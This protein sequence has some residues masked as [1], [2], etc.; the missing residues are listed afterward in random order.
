MSTQN[1]GEIIDLWVALDYAIRDYEFKQNKPGCI[2]CGYN[3]ENRYGAETTYWNYLSNAA[4]DKFKSSMSYE[5]RDQYKKAQGGELEEKK[6]KYGDTCPP[7][8]ASF[9]SSSRFVYNISREIDGFNF[10][11]KLPTKVGSSQANI[12]GY[13][14]H[15]GTD[16]FVEAKCREIYYDSY[17]KQEVSKSYMEIYTELKKLYPG[18]SFKDCGQKDK[19][20]FYCTFEFNG[21]PILHFDVKQL[22]SHFLGITAGILEGKVTTNVKFVYL[23]FNPYKDGVSFD[24]EKIKSYEEDIKSVYDKAIKEVTGFDMRDLFKAVMEIQQ[25]RLAKLPSKNDSFNF[26]IADQNDYLEILKK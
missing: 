18:F 14:K 13:L 9:G 5:H 6:G 22:I 17:E 26:E 1:Y 10:E 8:M 23:I 21:E 24:N 20:R 25:K 15:N 16:I 2:E 4:F 12:D 19:N 3:A 11:R 7:K